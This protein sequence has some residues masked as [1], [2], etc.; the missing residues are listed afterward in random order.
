MLKEFFEKKGVS[1]RIVS[2]TLKWLGDC[3]DNRFKGDIRLL[4]NTIE[5]FN[6]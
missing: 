6:Q 1:G 5:Q 3:D 2:D 4:N